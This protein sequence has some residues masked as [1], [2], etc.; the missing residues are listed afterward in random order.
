MQLEVKHTSKVSTPANHT[1]TVSK[2]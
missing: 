1:A 2:W